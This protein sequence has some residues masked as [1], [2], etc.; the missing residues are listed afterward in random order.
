LRKLAGDRAVLRALHFFQDNQRVLDQVE[1]LRKGN[2]DEFLKLVNASGLSSSQ[3][4]QNSYPPAHP[5]E[6]GV[7]LALALT[8][9]YLSTQARGACRVHGGGFAGTIQVYIPEEGVEGYREMMEPVFGE[10]AVVDLRIR[11]E[12]PVEVGR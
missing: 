9:Q 3:W 12:G 11:P 1:A 5:S 7:S 4:L 6:Q 8:R 10:D 2:L